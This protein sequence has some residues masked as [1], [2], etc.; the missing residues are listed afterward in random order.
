M[1]IGAVEL[2][3]HSFSF[4]LE[5]CVKSPR[6]L[7]RIDL[8]DRSP[9]PLTCHALAGL[10]NGPMPESNPKRKTIRLPHWQ[11]K[12]PG[13]ATRVVSRSSMQSKPSRLSPEN[14]SAQGF[15]I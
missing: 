14:K 4:I 11:I 7:Y 6:G 1:V 12:Q 10:Q 8:N 3:V 15:L 5:R 13:A 2:H 9:S